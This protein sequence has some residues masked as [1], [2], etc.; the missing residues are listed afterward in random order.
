MV[1]LYYALDSQQMYSR[2]LYS[3]SKALYKYPAVLYWATSVAFGL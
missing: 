1:S 3:L 2:L